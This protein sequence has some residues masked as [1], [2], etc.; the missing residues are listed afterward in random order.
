MRSL[1]EI[2]N[3][4]KKFLVA[5]QHEIVSAAG[6]LIMISLV[7]KVLGMLFLTLVA[8]QFGA[9]TETDLFYLASIL[10]ETITNII[11][12]GVISGSIIPIFINIKEKDGEIEVLESD[13][14][15]L[16][17]QVRDAQN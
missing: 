3:L 1:K 5:E 6:M 14:D 11:L 2:L 7:T 15:D 13:N 17:Q 12:L 8:R 16:K 10:P 9:S 4:L